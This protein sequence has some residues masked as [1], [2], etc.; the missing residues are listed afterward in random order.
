MRTHTQLC[1]L[2]CIFL[3]GYKR[4]HLNNTSVHIHT[5]LTNH[6]LME[7]A[8]PILFLSHEGAYPLYPFMWCVTCTYTQIK[9]TC[10]AVLYVVVYLLQLHIKCSLLSFQRIII[11]T[12]SADNSFL[13]LWSPHCVSRRW[14]RIVAS[15]PLSLTFRSGH[16]VS[17]GVSRFWC[18]FQ[19]FF[20]KDSLWVCYSFFIYF[21][22]FFFLYK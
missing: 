3:L 22:I 12:I 9:H 11:G 17:L 16:C 15:L 20:V 21:F 4:A 19:Y 10:A 7:V 6:H 18:K 2:E 14:H 8:I 5:H 1:T 13:E